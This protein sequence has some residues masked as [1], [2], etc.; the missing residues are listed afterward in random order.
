MAEFC[1]KCFDESFSNL[2][3]YNEKVIISKEKDLCEGCG[4]WDYVVD[5]VEKKGFFELLVDFSKK[6]G[7]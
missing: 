4:G 6:F 1:K 5:R 2:V 3:G 7:M